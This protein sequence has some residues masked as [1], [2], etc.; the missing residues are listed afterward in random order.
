MPIN[1]LHSHLLVSNCK[2]SSL[3]LQQSAMAVKLPRFAQS[4]LEPS[5][6]VRCP[7]GRR[8]RAP[9]ATGLPEAPPAKKPCFGT[10][11]ALAAT[12]ALSEDHFLA[13]EKPEEEKSEEDKRFEHPLQV[14][15]ADDPNKFIE[16]RRTW[17]KV[18][19]SSHQSFD[20]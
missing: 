11:A 8:L 15:A 2:P 1:R 16:K 13:Q 17:D 3:N 10:E 4:R 19:S 12:E 20:T 6:P 7:R 14:P 18:F 9:Q 5:R